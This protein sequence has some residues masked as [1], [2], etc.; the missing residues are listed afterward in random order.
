MVL[1]VS[2][3]VKL[4]KN[5]KVVEEL[6]DDLVD[7]SVLQSILTRCYKMFKV[8]LLMVEGVSGMNSFMCDNWICRCSM[9]D[10]NIWQTLSKVRLSCL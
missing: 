10:F 9:E 2:N 4:S 8:G 5:R 3:P 1:V 7:E 6:H